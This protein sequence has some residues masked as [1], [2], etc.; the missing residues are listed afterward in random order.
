MP[1]R[2]S[3]KFSSDA[4]LSVAATPA[5]VIP[6]LKRKHPYPAAIEDVMHGCIVDRIRRL[7]VVCA[8]TQSARAA[9]PRR[10]GC[11]A[12]ASLGTRAERALANPSARCR[13]PRGPDASIRNFAAI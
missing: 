11:R 7:L 13:N 12:P 3:A 6:L 4:T 8:E 10:S 2:P 5:L 1:A 9:P